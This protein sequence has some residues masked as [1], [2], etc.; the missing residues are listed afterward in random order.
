MDIDVG[1]PYLSAPAVIK[2]A[3]QA[4]GTLLVTLIF[5]RIMMDMVIRTDFILL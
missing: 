2:F 4:E 1:L 5:M 3:I